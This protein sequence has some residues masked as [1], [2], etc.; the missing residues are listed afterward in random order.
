MYC[1]W[2]IN[3]YIYTLHWKQMILSPHNVQFWWPCTHDRLRFRFLADG[4]GVAVSC[5]WKCSSDHHGCKDWWLFEFAYP[6][7]K[8]E[9]NGQPFSSD[10][11]RQKQRV[12]TQGT[13]YSVA[14]RWAPSRVNSTDGAHVRARNFPGVRAL[15]ESPGSPLPT[16]VP[17]RT[18]RRSR[19]FFIQMSGVN[20][21]WSP[22]ICVCTI[23]CTETPP[24]WLGKRTKQTK[25]TPQQ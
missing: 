17:R 12:S 24:T 5:T 14:L 2:F 13:P 15:S 8:F 25:T 19:L 7:W 1:F 21:T 22:H 3:K 23:L 18:S 4:R 6:S 10:P 9:P 20:I 16:S 11:F